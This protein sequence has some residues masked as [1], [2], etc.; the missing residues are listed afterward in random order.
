MFLLP[1]SQALHCASSGA[2]AYLI[3]PPTSLG[4]IIAFFCLLGWLSNLLAMGSDG[5]REAV[6]MHG[7]TSS[8][9]VS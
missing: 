9:H 1:S 3:L 6:G 4:E 5:G 2:N 7:W 8:Y